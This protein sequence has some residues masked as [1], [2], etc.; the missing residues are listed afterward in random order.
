MVTTPLYPRVSVR[1]DSPG[2]LRVAIERHLARTVLARP[3]WHD[4]CSWS[5]TSKRAQRGSQSR[6]DEDRV[7]TTY[8]RDEL[9]YN[10]EFRCESVLRQSELKIVSKIL[11]KINV[12]LK[13]LSVRE[14]FL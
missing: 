10:F 3:L 11:L 6:R 13:A 9:D 5:L 4:K 8:E 2:D 7:E 14:P 12:L 1:V